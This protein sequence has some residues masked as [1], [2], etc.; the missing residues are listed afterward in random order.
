[1]QHHL[2]NHT[3]HNPGNL[4]D[5]TWNYLDIADITVIF[6]NTFAA[7]ISAPTFNS[8]KN[9]STATN[10][11][12]SAFSIMLHSLGNIPDDLVEWTAEEMKEMAAW[13]FATSTSVAGEYWHS[14]SSMLDTFITKYAAG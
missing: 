13:N 1:L 10:L 4:P 9:F 12:K 14:F 11:P 7:F 2:T 3:V 8:L 5:I 6:E